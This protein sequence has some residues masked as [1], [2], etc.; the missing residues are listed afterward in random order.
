MNGN[1]VGVRFGVWRNLEGVTKQITIMVFLALSY[2]ASSHFFLASFLA[3]STDPSYV[4]YT[5]THTHSPPLPS[6]LDLGVIPRPS[7]S[8]IGLIDFSQKII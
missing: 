5:H 1:S 7:G 4:F 2:S 6:G 3:E 8:L